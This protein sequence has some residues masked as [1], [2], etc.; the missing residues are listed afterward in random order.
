MTDEI[1]FAKE[2]DNNTNKNSVRCQYCNSIILKPKSASY[3]ENE[4]SSI[5]K[6]SKKKQKNLKIQT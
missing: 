5:K 1:N 4:V 6:N 2:I 3:S